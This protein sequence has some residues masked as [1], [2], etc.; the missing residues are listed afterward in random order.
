MNQ[1]WTDLATRAN[2][3]L[4]DAQ[5][6]QLSRYLDLLFE[7][8]ARMNLTRITE[9]AATELQHV[10]DS[11]TVLPHLPAGEIGPQI[12]HAGIITDELNRQGRQARQRNA[13]E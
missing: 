13:E 2:V 12:A 3:T 6:A 8:N 7:A 11:L 1:L 10:G 9:R 4:T 5:H